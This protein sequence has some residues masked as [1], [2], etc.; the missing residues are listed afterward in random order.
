[1]TGT[2]L[3]VGATG[4]TGSRTVARLV[5][6]GYGVRAA[7]RRGAAVPGAEGVVLD[8]Y[9]PATHAPALDGVERVYLV[10]PVG[11]PEPVAV[12]GPF[13]RAAAAAGVRRAVLL[14]GAPIAEGGPAIGQVHRIL[15]DLIEQ[16]AVLRPSWFMQNFTGTHVH[17]RSIR[18]EGAIRS[19]TGDGRV[20]FVDAGDIAAVA[21]HALTDDRAPDT[22]LVLTGPEA[23]SYGDIAEI[24]TDV[25][26]R[27][28]VHHR[29]SR[30]H[31][32]DRFAQEMAPEWA[33][34]LADMERDIAAGSED[35]VTDVVE[36]VTGRRP[37]SFRALLAEEGWARR[38]VLAEEG[39]ARP[40]SGDEGPGG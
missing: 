26:G 14:S 20:G 23:L 8:W 18:E 38:A 2:T 32:R 36:R 27:A 30:D 15:P 11:D 37:R 40:G 29:M 10:P 31:V 19:A 17:A 1:M 34:A 35:R 9:D 4:T 5:A 33:A 3:V 16:W 39:P 13:L 25:S 21:F 28:V 6:A 24:V 22:D 12:M 7:G